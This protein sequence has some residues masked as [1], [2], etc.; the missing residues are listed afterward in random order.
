MTGGILLAVVTI[1][2]FGKGYMFFK[3]NPRVSILVASGFLLIGFFFWQFAVIG[4]GY[5]LGLALSE[6][7]SRD[8]DGD[9]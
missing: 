5:T 8:E 3:I 2:T 7:Y 9:E 6:I 1:M 4:L